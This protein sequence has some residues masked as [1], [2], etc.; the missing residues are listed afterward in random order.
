MKKISFLSLIVVLL[1][2]NIGQGQ[3][4]LKNISLEDIWLNYSFYPRSVRGI[5]SL[6]NGQQYTTIKKGSVIVYDYK[7]GDSITTLVNA[8][9]LIPE[10]QE[11]P[12]KLKSFSMSKD[13]TKFLIPTET[14]SIY[15]HSS[16]SKFYIWD[17]PAKKLIN[18]STEKQRFAHFSPDGNKVAFVR[19]NNIFIRNLESG[20]EKQVTYDGKFNAIINGTC[21]WVYE[22]EFGFTKA[23]FWSPDGNKIAYYRFDESRVKEYT[24]TNYGELYPELYTYKYPKA[25]EDNSVVEIF[26]YDL[27]K[28]ESIKMDIG[29]ETDQYIPRIKWT[30]DPNVL[31]I[32][33]LN[34]LQNHL[35]ILLANGSNGE[36]QILYTE[37]NKYYIDITDDL[38]F[39]P[40]NKLFLITSEKDGYNHIYLYNID[41]TLNNQLTVGNWD[42]S[43]VYGYD[44]KKKQVF[45]QSS[46]D[47]PLNRDIYVV[48]L[49]GKRTIISTHEGSND[50]AFSSNYKYFINTW[51]DANTP[52]V[53]T[54]NQAN[55]KEVRMLEDNQGLVQKMQNFN[56]S[57]QFFFQ[58]ESPEF[59]MPDGKQVDLNA[60]AIYPPDFDTT[61]QYPVL[62]TIYGGPGSQTVTNSFGYFNY[63]WYQML[64]QNGIIVISVDNRGTGARG[65]EFR[66]MTYL[67]LGKYETIDYIE[68]AKYLGNLDY[69]D[70]N[71]IGIF[72][73]SYGGFMAANA[74]FQG[75]D[76]FSTAIAVAPVSNWRYYDNIYTERFM[77]TPQENPEGYD[78]NSPINHVDNMKGDFL[79]IHGSADDNV[80]FQN[81]MDLITALVKANK[82]F[83]LMAYP[84]KNH[85]IYG[86]NTRYHLFKRMTDFLFENMMEENK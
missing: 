34:R 55:G 21:D 27:E 37:D 26:V 50:A 46:E 86:G 39:L 14:E 70:K 56:L 62:I 61:K 71:R 33:R 44:T 8:E 11:E 81:T 76:Y 77:R 49:K 9:E 59:T 84:N 52:P 41:G 6:N 19:D 28:N 38:T 3:D 60:W 58:I 36:S 22:E 12:I 20:E 78:T 64:A 13:E 57:E 25:G 66:K 79:L 7:T 43:K 18:L 17:S 63:F 24:I 72:G 48:N 74:L 4:T 2:V 40:G 10:G 32:Q 45:Y 69:V 83:D 5:N 73:W 15:R 30:Q 51:K 80:H 54:V 16:E 67:Q 82:Q 65:E 47:S 42:V 29:E 85:G 31:S 75:S 53:I 35:D 68:T 1:T 23:F